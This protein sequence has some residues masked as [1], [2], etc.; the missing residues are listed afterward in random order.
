MK[1]AHLIKSFL[2]SVLCFSTSVAW[3]QAPDPKTLTCEDLGFVLS[4]NKCG[5]APVIKCP[6]DTSKVMC[7][8]AFVGE[9]RIYSGKEET[10]PLGWIRADGRSLS[11][12]SYPVL[13]GTIGTSFGG[14]GSTF[15]LPNL[16]GRFPIGTSSSYSKG[17]TGGYATHTLSANEMPSHSHGYT[18]QEGNALPDGSTDWINEGHTEAYPRY[19][20]DNWQGGGQ[21]HNNMPPYVS[22]FYIIFTGVYL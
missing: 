20:Q 8:E 17:N 13:Y 15:Y 12:T 21:P 5:E 1:H 9:I 6:F 16:S 7:E 4:P 19:T 14:Y 2:F 10:I 18:G 3:A 11:V 22:L